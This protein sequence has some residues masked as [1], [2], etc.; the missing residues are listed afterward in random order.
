MIDA[1]KTWAFLMQ[2]LSSIDMLAN[3]RDAWGRR[4]KSK[5]ALDTNGERGECDFVD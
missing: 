2:D 1:S 3:E 4:E 5:K